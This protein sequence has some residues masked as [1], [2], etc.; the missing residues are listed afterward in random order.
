VENCKIQI[1]KKFLRN[2]NQPTYIH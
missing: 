2:H 1:T